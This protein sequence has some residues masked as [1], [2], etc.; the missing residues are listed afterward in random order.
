M[1]APAPSAKSGLRA[2]QMLIGGEWVDGEESFESIDPSSGEAWAIIPNATPQDVDR[3]VAAAR[4][5]FTD[6]P[7]SR[8]TP[9]DRG[10]LMY[11]LAELVDVHADALAR[12]ESRDNGKLLNETRAQAA[13][14]SRWYRFYAGLADKIEGTVPAIDMPSVLGYVVPEPRGVIAA[15]AAWN[16]P[17]M[18]ATWKIA[19]ALAAGNTVVAKPSEATSASLLELAAMFV[20]IGFP[21]GVLNVVTGGASSGARLTAHP[22]VD[23]VT[24]TGGPETARRIAHATAENLTPMTLE[25]GGKSAN[26]VFE[27]CDLDAAEAGVLAGIFAASGQTCIAGS[28]LLVQ[29][30]IEEELVTRLVARARQITLGDPGDPSTQMGPIATEQQLER[31]AAY[32]DGAV[33]DGAEAVT[34]GGRPRDA[35]LLGGLYFEPTILRSVRPFDRVAQEEIFGPVLVVLPFTDEEEAVEIA[36]GTR[37]GLAAGIWT[38]DI[39]RAH[40]VAGKLRSGTVWVNMYRGASPM[41]PNG[42]SGL[43]GY[44]RENGI[45][46]IEEFTHPKGV[47]VELSDA[48]HDP[49]QMRL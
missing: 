12:V 4:Q 2:Y 49:F 25:L 31:I 45:R 13:A 6:G 34:G 44:G 19:P 1:S 23:H 29:R 26:I 46:A 42:G 32:V 36:N 10:R 7:W 40:R 21:P 16:S 39:K 3:A 43:S 48:V 30:S 38:R 5:A 33:A 47:W 9:S 11:R 18:L 35:A 8:M 17:L 14:L 37:Y 20:E 41:M 24:F 15:I 27:D 22:D 28:R